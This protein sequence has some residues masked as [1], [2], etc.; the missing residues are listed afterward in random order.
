MNQISPDARRIAL[1][2]AAAFFMQLLDGVII[3]VALPEMA[4]SLGVS[5]LDMSV[6]VTSYILASAIFIPVAGWLADRFGPQRIFL[7]AIILFTLASVACGLAQS[8]PQFIVARSIQGIGGAFMIPVGRLIVLRN[9]GKHELVDAIALITWPA[10]IAPVI[11]PALGGAITTY[12]SWRW[13]FFIN[14]PLG[15]IGIGLV[16]AFIPKSPDRDRRPLDWPGF[17]LTS[18]SLGSLLYGLELF[19]HANGNYVQPISLCLL[20]LLTG[21]SAIRH[22]SRT[23]VPL[24]DL[25]TFRRRTF[26]ISNLFAGGYAR[27]S[28]NAT[29]FLLPL[30]F[31]ISFGLDPLQAGGLTIAY[32]AGNLAMK[33]VTT[34]ILRRFGFR[35]VLVVNGVLSA[36]FIAACGALMPD[37]PYG[38]VLGILFCAGLTRSMQL[39]ALNTIAFADV[40]PAERSSASTLSSMLQQVSMVLGVA[41]A[42]LLLN[43]SQA[44]GARQSLALVDFQ[45]A[46]AAIAILAL[47]SAGLMLRLPA[48]AG[49]AV[50]GHGKTA[51]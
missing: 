41:L 34:R 48:D 31:Q 25:N 8:L 40:E 1:I 20:G 51:R 21:A 36:I 5:T 35:L 32:F 23:K 7:L 26:A 38:L 6:G 9:A 30:L 4:L 50:S 16:L 22:L 37:T 12:I 14:I 47:I 27:I 43:A 13:N 39:T 42:A 2:V 17:I 19:V 45:I 24:L 15:I 49:S 3:V 18:V 10:L 28:I 46:F 29:P 11:G 44:F 33:T